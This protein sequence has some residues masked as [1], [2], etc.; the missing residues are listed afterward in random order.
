MVRLTP[1]KLASMR[2]DSKKLFNETAEALF[3]IEV[4]T[5]VFGKARVKHL[6][7]SAKQRLKRMGF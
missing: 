3:R 5:V 1:E 6:L 2:S 7:R 4:P